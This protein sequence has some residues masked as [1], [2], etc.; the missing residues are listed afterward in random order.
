MAGS[1]YFFLNGEDSDGL[2]S[3]VFTAGNFDAGGSGISEFIVGTSGDDAVG[4]VILSGFDSGVGAGILQDA[5]NLDRITFTS[6]ILGDGTGT[7][8]LGGFDFNGDG[9]SDVAIGAP[10]S[11]KVFV[12]YGGATVMGADLTEADLTGNVGVVISDTA[13]GFGSALS[14]ADL[15]NDGRDELIIGAPDFG[16]GGLAGQGQA[17]TVELT[18]AAIVSNAGVTG[19]GAGD[20]L[21][22]A[23]S[24]LLDVNG[25][26]LDDVIIAAPGANGATSDQGAAYVVFGTNG[27]NP[28]AGLDLST[29]NGTNGFALT[30][31]NFADGAGADVSVAGDLNGD[32]TADLLISAP[33]HDGSGNNSGESYVI[34][35]KA[36]GGFGATIDLGNLG[37][38]GLTISGTVAG[39]LTGQV[40][41]GVGDVSGD[42]AHDL[43]IMGQD[44]AGAGVAYLLFGGALSTGALSLGSISTAEGFKF[45]GL[46]LGILGDA[47][48][49]QALGDINNDGINDIALTAQGH[50][51]AD[52]GIL[53][54]LLGG[55]EN[56]KALDG[57][58]DGI[59]DLANVTDGTPPSISFVETNTSVTFTGSFAGALDLRVPDGSDTGDFDIIDTNDA[60]ATFNTAAAGIAES[61]GTFG[62]I[63]VDDRPTG[64]RWIYTL[65]AMASLEYLGGGET[66][67]D[68]VILTASNGSQ[69]EIVLTITGQDDATQVTLTPD[70]AVPMT[71]D[72]ASYSGD[73]AIFDPDQNDDPDLAG[74]TLTSTNGRIEIS[75]DGTRFTFFLDSDLTGLGFGDVVTETFSATSNGVNVAFSL[76]IEG[77]DEGSSGGS[78]GSEGALYELQGTGATAFFGNGDSEIVGTSGGDRIDGGRGND[79]VAGGD[80]NDVITDSFGDDVVVAGAGDDNVSLLSGI[81]TISDNTSGSPGS[82]GSNYFKGGI[83]QDTLIGGAGNDVLD[84]DAVSNILGG[85]D[86][87]QGGAGDDVVRGG[88]GADV[89]VFT[90]SDGDNR[91]A[92]FDGATYSAALGYQAYGFD[93]DFDLGLDVI[94]LS[95]FGTL[96]STQDALD[97]VSDVGGHATF[98]AQGTTITLHGILTA[99]LTIDTFIL[100]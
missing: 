16:T 62:Q 24:G 52:G 21:G 79:T 1:A 32:G 17:L 54:G 83:G 81:N 61:T 70:L 3:S 30:G 5:S 60:G 64:E 91:I 8:V 23:I 19:L 25:D 29:L 71:E 74:A 26:G 31:I 7:A 36:A 86:R 41:T 14:A 47:P 9:I 53:I 48:D 58:A 96:A 49:G 94:E 6:S 39:G 35:G 18:G 10:G 55:L 15:D 4:A 95:G 2:G 59:I 11:G 92:D 87:I 93:R 22:S 69:R 73:F 40:A 13:A 38:G 43:L 57:D 44:G 34:Y 80:G 99:D 45:T 67:E 75:A 66:V 89:F 100:A 72:L 77:R 65:T 98:A 12:I 78:A 46:D 84:G 85:N 68:V 33:S 50:G 90:P 51:L 27:S 97:A 82:A 88:L 42:G 37:T 76:D 28:L 56:L 63:E 20:A